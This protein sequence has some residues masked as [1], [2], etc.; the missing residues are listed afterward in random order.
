[1]CSPYRAPEL[2]FGPRTYDAFAI[3]TW[4]L[5]VTFAEFFTS[6]RLQADDEDDE[7]FSFPGPN[8]TSE[9]ESGSDSGVEPR[10]PTPPLMPFVVPRGTHIPTGRWTRTS[11]F[12]G[13]RG[14]IGLAWSIFKIR[15]TPNEDTWP[16]RHPL[17]G[18]LVLS[19]ARRSSFIRTRPAP[20][21]HL[22]G[23]GTVFPDP[24]GCKQSLL[25]RRG[26]DGLGSAPPKL[27]PFDHDHDLPHRHDRTR[28]LP[29]PSPLPTR[30]R[31][32]FPRV[33]TLSSTPPLRGPWSSLVQ[34]RTR[35]GVTHRR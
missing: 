13:T 12:D 19:R 14:E 18:S 16:V 17:F 23:S 20:V 9:S 4:S 30:P 2:L 11:L 1:M 22:L 6:L 35:I 3:D 5:G 31:P 24:P 34:S 33:R 7:D 21:A 28:A 26:R 29:R 8:R 32:P 15:G 25:C 10:A 27:A